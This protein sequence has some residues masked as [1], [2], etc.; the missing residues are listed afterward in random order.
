MCYVSA[1]PD[2]KL[3][4]VLIIRVEGGSDCFIQISGIYELSAF[5][6]SLERLAG[7]KLKKDPSRTLQSHRLELASMRYRSQ[8]DPL[9]LMEY[10]PEVLEGAETSEVPPQSAFAPLTRTGP[11]PNV[12]EGP[13]GEMIPSQLSKILHHLCKNDRLNTPDLFVGGLKELLKSEKRNGDDEVQVIPD[14]PL[15]VQQE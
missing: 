11:R 4:E 5:G 9:E 13:I 1:Y 12:V 10:L 14:F 7:R 8:S 2:G 3:D 15:D 6:L